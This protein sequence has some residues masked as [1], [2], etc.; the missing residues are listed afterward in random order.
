MIVIG[1]IF[2]SKPILV[3]FFALFECRRGYYASFNFFWALSLR[4]AE[5]VF[6]NLYRW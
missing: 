1:Q 3:R 4:I 6:Q 2:V 5:K